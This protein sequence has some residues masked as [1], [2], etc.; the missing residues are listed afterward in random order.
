MAQPKYAAR[1]ENFFLNLRLNRDQFADM[2]AFTLQALE[3]GGPAFQAVAAALATSLGGYRTTHVGQLSG[4]ARGAV[5]T[6]AQAL[7]DFK[8]YVKK[9]ER[10]FVI[11][12]YEEKS[13][14]FVAIFPNGRGGLAKANQTKVED[15]FEAFL[16]AL[17]DRPTVFP[18][19]LRKEGRETILPNLADALKRA[20]TQA[21]TTDTQR[22]DLHDGREATCRALFRAYATL[23]LEYADQPQRAAA[24]FDLSKADTGGGKKKGQLPGIAPKS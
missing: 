2:A 22:I 20:D 8:A 18:S 5:V 17:D 6:L 7:A 14:D 1:F 3:Q 19:P 10:K 4:A 16:N 11:P 21:T 23:L 9:V 12:N 13:A 24:F 15:A